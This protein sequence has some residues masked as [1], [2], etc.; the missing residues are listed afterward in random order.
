MKGKKVIYLLKNNV[1]RGSGWGA[2]LSQAFPTGSFL[3]NPVGG[4]LIVLVV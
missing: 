2:P 1:G 3:W 4:I